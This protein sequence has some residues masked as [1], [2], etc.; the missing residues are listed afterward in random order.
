MNLHSSKFCSAQ[1]VGHLHSRPFPVSGSLDTA[2][3]QRTGHAAKRLNA[4]RPYLLDHWQ[5]VCRKLI[6]SLSVA[7]PVQT[8]RELSLEVPP[9]LLAR[10]VSSSCCSAARLRRIR[11]RTMDSFSRRWA[12]GTCSSTCTR[13]SAL[14]EHAQVSWLRLSGLLRAALHHVGTLLTGR[15]EAAR[16]TDI[17]AASKA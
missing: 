6:S 13:S 2:S 10:A 8:A 14:D 3:C 7:L 5:H 15:Q 16:G 4:A 9:T 12:G 11:S 17:V 1:N